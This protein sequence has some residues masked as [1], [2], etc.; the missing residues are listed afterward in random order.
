MG[1]VTSYRVVPLDEVGVLIDGRKVDLT[2]HRPID[3]DDQAL[4][5]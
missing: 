5:G 1:A 4:A 2:D 3:I